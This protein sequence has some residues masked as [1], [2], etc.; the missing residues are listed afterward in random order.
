M[1]Q[2]TQQ[3]TPGD[4]ASGSSSKLRCADRFHA[5]F[6]IMGRHGAWWVI[7][8]LVIGLLVTGV[9]TRLTQSTLEAEVRQQFEFDCQLLKTRIDERLHDHEQILRS[10]AAFFADGDGVTR[11]EWQA[12]ATRQKISQ[13]LPGIQGIGFA[14][15][16]AGPQLEEHLRSVRAEGFPDYRVWPEGKREIYSS[17]VF[18][19][20]FSGRNLRA[21]GYDMLTEPVRRAAMEQARDQDEAILSGKVTLI[22]ETSTHIQAG[23]LMY[24][25]VYQMN[26]PIATVA[27]RRRALMGWV[28][29]PY[30]MD[31]LMIGILQQHASLS[32]HQPILLK[33]FDGVTPETE[34][35]LYDSDRG[36]SSLSP[37]VTPMTWETT[38]NAAGRQWLLDFTKAGG[39]RGG[40]LYGK[41]WGVLAGGG[42]ISLLLAAL[43]FSLANTRQKALNRAEHLAEDL[44]QTDTERNRIQIEL[45]ELA[46]IQRALLELATRFVNIPYGQQ[47]AAIDESLAT[48]GQLIAADR[49]YL[50]AYDFTA[51]SLSNTHEWCAPDTPSRIEKLQSMPMAPFQKWIDMHRRGESVHVPNVADLPSD[52]PLRHLLD[53]MGVLSL[54]SLPLMHD[55]TC[56]GAISFNAFQKPRTWNDHEISLLSALA[57]IYT[58]FM[59]RGRMEQKAITLQASLAKTNDAAQAATAAKSL[60]LANMSHEIRTPLNSILGYAQIMERECASCPSKARLKPITRSGEHLLTLIRNLLDLARNESQQIS[61]TPETFDFHQAIDDVRLMFA[62]HMMTSGL[63]FEVT[64]ASD[65][66][67]FL[68]ADAT[69]IRQ[70]LVNLV[71]NAIKFTTQGSIR[72]TTSLLTANEPG[73]TMHLAMD[74]KDTGCGIHQ[75]ELESIF[76][77]FKQAAHGQ[78]SGL[79]TGL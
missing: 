76:L 58:H 60:F 55:G 48:M 40:M 27:E 78:K 43:V 1:H 71:G 20:P 16:L 8:L 77:V 31:D 5:I 45:A 41:A 2:T 3:P 67:Q 51:E 50:M 22:Q 69:K 34:A 39:I 7:G 28:Y 42:T 37:S 53:A 9:A 44:Q 30:R 46:P 17:I 18:L 49:A 29:S 33:I 38:L 32:P 54:I 56:L 65:V 23:T 26:A 35:L 24:V 70:I 47:N 74:I 73:G 61:I 6:R 36:T 13:F 59:I 72:V 21:F 79:G 19:E 4:E 62:R 11:D 68:H 52:D 25:P 12:F 63:T 57:E 64:R 15:Q 75:D 10:A 14:M 66:P